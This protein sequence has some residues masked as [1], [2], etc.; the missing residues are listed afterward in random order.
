MSILRRISGGFRVAFVSSSILDVYEP[1]APQSRYSLSAGVTVSPAELDPDENAHP[2]VSVVVPAYRPSADFGG[3]VSAI[4][5]HLDTLPYAAELIV[6]DDGSPEPVE[7]LVRAVPDS[8]R[9]VTVV[10]SHANRGKGAAVALGMSIAR[11]DV[12]AFTDADLS[13]PPSQL[14]AVCDPIRHGEADVAVAN[15]LDPQSRYLM[16]PSFFHYLYT[17]HLSSR[18]F[19]TVVRW[20]LLPGMADTQAGLKAF[21]ARAAEIIFPRL[22]IDGFGFD[23]EALVIARRHGLTVRPTP[24]TFVYDD[25][26]S[27]VS[28]ARDTWRMLGDVRRVAWNSM[29]DRYA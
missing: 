25:E 26:P 21:S 15:R 12:R 22:T 13:Y 19:N 5:G 27:T 6:V 28:F 1:P 18:C 14:A 7:P 3:A 20:T 2:V 8:G 23:V 16:S 24:V 29:R 11:G 10:R 17:R 4:R 9:R